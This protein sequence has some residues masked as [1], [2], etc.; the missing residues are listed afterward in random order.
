MGPKKHKARFFEERNV[1]SGMRL[2][3]DTAFLY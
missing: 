1:S 2:R 3:A